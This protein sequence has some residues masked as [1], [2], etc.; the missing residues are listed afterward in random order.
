[1]EGVEG[2]L[3]RNFPPAHRRPAV[4]DSLAVVNP[5]EAVPGALGPLSLDARLERHRPV[6][7]LSEEAHQADPVGGDQRP[8]E[9]L[10]LEPDAGEQRG[11]GSPR[12]SSEGGALDLGRAV[13]ET[14]GLGILGPAF[15]SRLE[16][17]P[18]RRIFE[19][20]HP[21][22]LHEDHVEISAPEIG[23][24]R[25]WRLGDARGRLSDAGGREVPGG[26]QRGPSGRREL[27]EHEKNER[28]EAE[29]GA[30]PPTEPSPGLREDSERADEEQEQATQEEAG[31]RNQECKGQDRIHRPEHFGDVPQ[32]RQVARRVE[33]P[34]E[35]FE[36]D[37]A[38]NPGGRRR[39][40]RRREQDP[41]PPGRPHPNEQNADS[42]E[43]K[44][45]RGNRERRTHP[46]A[47]RRE[48]N[49]Q[50]QVQPDESQGDPERVAPRGAGCLVVHRKSG[51]GR[52]RPKY[53]SSA[54]RPSSRWAPT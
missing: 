4:A 51:R 30:A 7:R 18:P 42:H 10:A 50:Q 26:H 41:H 14:P 27:G 9:R 11:V 36:R 48:G 35:E 19:R 28:G 32:V 5:V 46:G 52:S 49:R 17:R 1:M 40:K 33:R 3:V 21:V 37:E 2:E 53:P 15:G 47:V 20:R 38:G 25:Q 16:T 44:K 39:K 54:S 12:P 45:I 23:H 31:E 13:V 24:S 8:V 6:A 29:S 43:D 34:P 22:G